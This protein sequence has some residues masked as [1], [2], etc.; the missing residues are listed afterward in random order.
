ML[1]FYERANS[2]GPKASE[3]F[4][5]ETAKPRSL[6]EVLSKAYGVVGTVKKHRLLFFSGRTRIHYD[7]VE[8]LG[9]FIELEV[10]LRDGESVAAGESKP[11]L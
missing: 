5:S 6:A 7:Y 4:L 11:P 9:T 2:F 8:D 1:I 3:F 10:V